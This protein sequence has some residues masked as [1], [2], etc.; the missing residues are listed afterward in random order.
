MNSNNETYLTHSLLRIIEGTQNNDVEKVLK[1]SKPLFSNFD[2]TQIEKLIRERFSENP[3]V[4]TF[5][6]VIKVKPLESDIQEFVDK[7]FWELT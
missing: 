2:F 7:N 5:D 6:K 1:Y 3:S 4:A